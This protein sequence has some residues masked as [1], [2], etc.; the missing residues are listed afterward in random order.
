MNTG[1]SLVKNFIYMHTCWTLET[2]TAQRNAEGTRAQRGRVRGWW[3]SIRSS[4]SPCHIE[5]IPHMEVYVSVV[6]WGL[7]L[8]LSNFLQGPLSQ[9]KI[10]LWA[11]HSITCFSKI[12][13]SL[14]S[15]WIYSLRCSSESPFLKFQLSTS[16]QQNILASLMFKCFPGTKCFEPVL[17]YNPQETL[18]DSWSVSPARG[19]TKWIE[20]KV[21]INRSWNAWGLQLVLFF[22]SFLIQPV[23]SI[24]WA[25]IMWKTL[26]QDSLAL[27]LAQVFSSCSTPGGLLFVLHTPY[28]HTDHLHLHLLFFFSHLYLFNVLHS[29]ITRLT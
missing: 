20:H 27:D 3:R 5:I 21:V 10:I 9:F 11:I 17:L 13:H 28:T 15:I 23:Q 7:E 22:A 2:P 26:G 18:W 29:E 24:F 1:I 8:V 14:I 19:F 16:L 12:Y 25:S 4:A 6:C